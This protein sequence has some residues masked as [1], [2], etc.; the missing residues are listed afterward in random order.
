MILAIDAGNT[1]VKWGLYQRGAWLAQG[2]VANVDMVRLAEAWR[3]FPVPNQVIISNVAGQKARSALTVLISH[4]HKE[5]TW[6]TPTAAEGG[7]INRYARPAQLG[8]DRWAAL[9]AARHLHG[10]SC[11]VVGIGTAVTCDVLTKEGEFLGGIIL[12]S[13]DLMFDVLARRTASVA[14]AKGT[15]QRFPTSTADGVFTGAWLA[16]AG[17]I[18]RMFRATMETEGGNVLCILHGGDAEVLR[19]LLN[20]PLRVED[21]LVLGGLIQL[22]Q[23]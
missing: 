14:P 8:S 7:V 11:L 21:N 20:I 22:A 9:V 18:D 3:P 17:A 5:A 6:V 12:P 23:A 16:V 15:L 10:G 2:A 19:P 1:R 4:W 13:P